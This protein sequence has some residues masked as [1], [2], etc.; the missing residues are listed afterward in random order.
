VSLGL[1]A[2]PAARQMSHMVPFSRISLAKTY[3]VLGKVLDISKD[4][5]DGD[6]EGYSGAEPRHVRNHLFQ[7]SSS[8]D[9]FKNEREILLKQSSTFRDFTNLFVALD[10]IEAWRDRAGEVSK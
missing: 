3:A 9:R 8:V 10:A 7:R 4:E 5:D 1:N 2:L 6:N